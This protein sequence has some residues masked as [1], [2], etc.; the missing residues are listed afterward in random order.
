MLQAAANILS[1][2]YKKYSKEFEW[3]RKF[4][5]RCNNKDLIGDLKLLVGWLVINGE[6]CEYLMY[7]L[8]FIIT[9]LK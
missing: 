3:V 5:D 7:L 2:H 6:W 1:K 4:F 8:V 9:D